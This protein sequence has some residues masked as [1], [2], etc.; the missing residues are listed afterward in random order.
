MMRISFDL[1]DT[2]ICY[3]P[4]TPREPRLPWYKRLIVG[5]EPL[6]RGARDLMLRLLEKGWDVWIYTTSRRPVASVRRWLRW[7][8][9]RV[10][11]IINQDVHEA[12]FNR[13]PNERPPSKNPRAFG[14]A[15]HVDDSD[16]VRMEGEVHG[17]DVVV[18]APDDET[19]SE[20]VLL[21]VDRIQADRAT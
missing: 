15:L 3:Q 13:S 1:D 19:W 10:A 14:M 2:L 12:H 6:R 11:G 9:I 7:H 21:A 8:G 4:G 20:K 18:I 16:G 17:F 5:H